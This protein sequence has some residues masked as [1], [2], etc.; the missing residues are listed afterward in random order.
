MRNRSET[1]Q[2]ME[3]DLAAAMGG[4]SPGR[5]MAEGDAPQRHAYPPLP[6]ATYGY[7]ADT[8]PLNPARGRPMLGDAVSAAAGDVPVYKR[9]MVT[10]V[11]G[12]ALVGGAWLF[13]DWIKPKFIDKKKGK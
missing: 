5:T 3:E 13:F 1:R 9:P 6:Y 11:A 8:N 10:F 4:P 12:A 2:L 7:P